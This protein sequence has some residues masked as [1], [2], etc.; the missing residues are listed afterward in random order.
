[1]AQ[2]TIQTRLCPHCANSIALDALTC[3]YCK[4]DL[5]PSA[6]P[7]WPRRSEDAV[8][9][10]PA[11]ENENLIVEKER[12]PVGSK[13]IL[14]L[15]LLVFAL[16]VYLVGGNR[17]RR[18]LTPVLTEQAKTLQEKDQKIQTLEAQLA[19]L[20][21]EHQGS[22]SQIEELKTK[23]QETEKDLASTRRKLTDANREVDRLAASRTASPSRSA[24]RT[25]EPLPP[26]A[27]ASARRS[28]EAGTY[29]TLRPATVY[30]EPSN[31]ARAIA[32]IGKGTEVTVV[33]SVGEWLE[34]RSKH[35]KPPGYIRSDDA[36]LLSRAN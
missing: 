2:A 1:M 29:E 10:S 35:G 30:E 5:I 12:L 17:E 13:V 14:A 7:E 20:R 15:G 11:A 23:F 9:R 19:Q 36:R 27:T 3:P 28:A 34:V 18:D 21:Q 26:P 4:A 22:S 24:T 6:A 8:W 25:T 33:R 16:G 32:Q 31:S